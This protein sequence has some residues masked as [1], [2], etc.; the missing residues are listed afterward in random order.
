MK[1]AFCLFRYFPYGGLQKDFMRIAKEAHRRGHDIT[2]FT[3]H[4]DGEKPEWMNIQLINPKGFTNHEQ[5]W[6]FS[7][8]AFE[9]ARRQH[10][11]RVVGFN[12]MH[13]LD[14]YYAADGCFVAK[15]SYRLSPWRRLLS[16]YRIYSRLERCV[17]S[18]KSN[19]KVLLISKPEMEN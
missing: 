19:T 4:W 7:H 18:S 3:M 2:V 11:D 8:A 1:I 9:K 10:F 16:R 13:G 5:A 6:R 12:K 15:E 17:F 14:V